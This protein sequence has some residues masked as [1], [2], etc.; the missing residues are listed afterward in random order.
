MTRERKNPEE[1]FWAKVQKQ[2]GDGCW[3]WTAAL[4]RNGYGHFSIGY[5][6]AYSHRYSYEI[7]VGPIP[8]GMC[9]CHKCD[10]RKCV[11]PDHLFLG[12][13]AENI[14]DRDAKGRT[15]TGTNGHYP[16]GERHHNAKLTDDQVRDLRR[17][18]TTERVTQRAL[19]AE[20]GVSYDSVKS[21]IQNRQRKQVAA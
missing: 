7:S 10:N 19:A 3:E 5:R 13:H 8:D 14:A 12:S 15:A 11:R 21:I 1:R 18:Y 2:E 9:V 20:F 17:R 16:T 6:D 4:H